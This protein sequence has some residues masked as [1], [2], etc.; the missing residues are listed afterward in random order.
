MA[1]AACSDAATISSFKNEEAMQVA[2]FKA[3]SSID[4]PAPGEKMETLETVSQADILAPGPLEERVLG[5]AGAAVTV[6]E[7]A[8]LTCPHCRA[9]HAT[10]FDAIKKAY[11]DTG[12][13]RW[14]LREFPIGHAS[15]NAWFITRCTPAKD[16][17]KLYNMYLQQQP[18]W[19]SQE[20][21]LDE[22]F[23]VA[24]QVGMK[25]AD[26]DACL[27]NKELETQLTWVKQRGRQLGVSGTPTF[28]IGT[29]KVRK[30]ITFDE[31]QAYVEPQLAGKV[32]AAQ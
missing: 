10:S 18:N 7:Y 31:F 27:K 24:A 13:V 11:I 16:Y 26:F 9:F 4:V 5:N 23:N 6:V 25:R 28:F 30:P 21:R 3:Q 29:E 12:K 22:I 15:G 14:I 17:F 1:L 8:S 2:S 32:A 19:V 20:V